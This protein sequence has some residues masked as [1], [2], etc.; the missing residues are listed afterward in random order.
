MLTNGRLLTDDDFRDFMFT[1]AVR[2]WSEVNPDF[3]KGTVV[4]K[5]AA[6]VLA[7]PAVRA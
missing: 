3:F 1:T 4:E 7:Q 6:E 2:F 5:R